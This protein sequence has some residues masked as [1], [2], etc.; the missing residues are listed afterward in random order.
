MANLY[1]NNN[2]NN[3][4]QFFNI[5]IFFYKNAR[6]IFKTIKRTRLQLDVPI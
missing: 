6:P 4:K 1:Q 3:K 2:N 5:I